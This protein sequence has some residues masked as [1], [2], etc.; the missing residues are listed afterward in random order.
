MGSH[1]FGWPGLS[2]RWAAGDKDFVLTALGTSQVWACVGGGVLNEVFWPNTGRPQL[3][4]LGFLVTG[5]GFWSEVKRKAKYTVTRH[6]ECAA[7]QQIV[8]THERYTLTLDVV[9]D[10]KR[11]V[12][13]VRFALLATN[14]SEAL[15]LHVLAAPHLGGTGNG[16]SAWVDGSTLFAQKDSEALA[17]IADDT[18]TYGSAG[19]VGQ[20]D[21]WQDLNANGKITWQFDHAENGN[22]ALTGTV[23]ALSG[24]I[25]IG[26]ST[27]SSG[28]KVLARAA[29]AEGFEQILL[30]YSAG[31]NA[32][33]DTINI[34]HIDPELDALALQSAIVLRV[35]EDTTFA[36]ASV[37]SLATPWGAWHDDP[38]G[39]HL[40]W[41]RDCAETGF[42]LLALGL[43]GEARKMLYFLAATQQS[44][45]HWNQ[46]FR[47]DGEPFWT[48]MQLDE[49]ALPVMLAAKLA[50]LGELL[51]SDVR[52]LRPMVRDAVCF[53]IA[54]GPTTDQDR[55]EETA[56]VNAFTL[57]AT[58]AAL[59]GAATSGLLDEAD[60]TEAISVADEW[61]SQIDQFLYV[62]GASLDET[63]GTK[64]HY[65]RVSPREADGKN[66]T[67]TIANR[68][69]ETA[70]ASW[71]VGM[72]FLALVR[73]G[74]RSPTDQRILDTVRIVDAELG[75]TLDGH[76]LYH[77]YQLDGYGEQE[78][79]SAFD[80]TGIGRLWPL[81][82]GERGNYAIDSDED[83]LP[84]LRAIVAS[85]TQGGMIPEQVWDA[86]P[87]PARR[88]YPGRPSGSAAPLVWAHAEYLK[89]FCAA[90]GKPIID[91]L[92][93]V[94]NRYLQ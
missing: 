28:A 25:A 6:Q 37:A 85:T 84:Y 81:L 13:L 5:D 10:S 88:L 24:T 54:N 3:R 65:V 90:T 43:V 55:W 27:T 53:L 17:I 86:A 46:N 47:P 26:F 15:E 92:Q 71:L 12:V 18:F 62:E 36:G 16:N 57:A 76:R 34:G 91:R 60:A 87:I 44:D 48:G 49:T 72:E 61:F 42:A 78:D 19:F 4:D 1:A 40:V 83:P 89:L 77:R 94:Q 82:T 33:L 22:V 21:G 74:L 9:C 11:D 93:S 75:Q 73:Y 64:G 52:A 67:V 41:P 7:S 29:L 79:G 66:G 56:G 50:E 35:H 31:W 69:G 51:E 32:W 38:G 23:A 45:G 63:Y 68:N 20:S 58:I 14:P 8:H 70:E 39:Y 80:G 30:A 2:P 59:V